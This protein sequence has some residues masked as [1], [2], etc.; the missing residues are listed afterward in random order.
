MILLY[1]NYDYCHILVEHLNYIFINFV[2]LL[3]KVTQCIK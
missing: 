1:I 3:T 2:H